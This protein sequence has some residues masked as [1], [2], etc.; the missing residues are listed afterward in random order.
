MTN[1][2]APD[3]RKPRLKTTDT[4]AA[5][6]LLAPF[7]L[8]FAAFV[9]Y[10][11]L[12]NLYLSFTDYS[13]A[14]TARW[15]G[16][17]NYERLIRDRVFC[18]AVSNTV[19]FALA[20][21]CGLMA[22]GLAAAVAMNR[23]LARAKGARMLCVYPY[24]TSMTAV[25]MIWLL[26][27]D[28]LSGYLNKILLALGFSPQPWLFSET[29]ALGCLVFVYIWKN[30]GYCMLV[31]LAGLQQTDR[32]LYE[33][34]RVD[35]ANGWQQLR[36]ITLPALLPVLLFVLVTSSIES[37]KTFE[38]VQVMTRGDPLHSTTTIVHQIY[39]RGFGEYKMGYAAAMSVAL[40]ALL[41]LVTALQ[42]RVVSREVG[43]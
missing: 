42:F 31:I 33:A 8:F 32:S 41:A 34:A 3:Y 1:R 4:R 22:F 23:P 11:A 26:L 13:L 37:F 28:P 7:L 30:M 2:R 24:A 39:L 40:L 19:L 43:E 21:V 6:A 5:Y 20:S 35:G 12:N 27:F 17:R 29:Q 18:R 10:P 25:S 16:L 38:L 15:I 9:L 14:G 36:R